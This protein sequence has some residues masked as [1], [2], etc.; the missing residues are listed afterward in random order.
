MKINMDDIDI[1]K[2]QESEIDQYLNLF[3][4][5]KENMTNPEWLGDF[6]K[7]DYIGL[8]N[9][10]SHIYAWMYNSEMIAAGILIP[11]TKK[12]LDKFF[13]RDLFYQKVVDFGPQIV[14]PKYIG[15][16]LQNQIIEFLERRALEL[17]YK[18]ALGTIHPDNIYS[19]KNIINKGFE[20]I[21][22]LELRRG[23]RKVYRKELKWR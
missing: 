8:M 6:S 7:K 9:N 13:S 16:G 18:Y 23:P 17:G 10:N 5:V 15:N 3:N 2:I 20:E 14:H 21:G 1:K 12:D 19:I 22:Y 4:V 11:A